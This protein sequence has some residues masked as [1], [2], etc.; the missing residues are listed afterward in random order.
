MKKLFLLIVIMIMIVPLAACLSPRGDTPEQKRSAIVKMHD[1]TLSRLYQQRPTARDVINKSAG[2]A[3][4]SNV[5]ALYLIVGGGGGYGVAVDRSSGHKTYMKMAQVDL[6]LGLGV[7]DIRVVFVFHSARAYMDFVN[8]GWEFGGQADAAAKARDKG[9]VATGEISIDAETT[10]YTMS[11][12]G[13][14]AKV[15]LAGT[16]YWKD[17]KLYY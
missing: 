10:M 1:D 12:A 11:E 16:K 9:A 3:V 5:N 14:M 4:F 7:Q 13:L 2:Y 15:N 6:G 17:D 8:S